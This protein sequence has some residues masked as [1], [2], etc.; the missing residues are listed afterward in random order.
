MEGDFI[1]RGSKLQAAPWLAPEWPRMALPM[2][3]FSFTRTFLSFHRRMRVQK[4]V[5][6]LCGPRRGL[7]GGPP[8]GTGCRGGG[9]PAQRGRGGR[10]PVIPGWGL[11]C[12]RPLLIK[13]PSQNSSLG[14][15]IGL[16]AL[17]PS[18][19]FAS[20]F[21]SALLAEPFLA[22]PP[23]SASCLLGF[24]AEEGPSWGAGPS[25]SL[26]LLLDS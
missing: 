14:L 9:G 5:R 6:G 11:F 19:L 10:G 22:S 16:R 18:P 17:S 3:A 24:R 1:I 4:C 12:L 23:Q 8:S 20:V 2:W 26:S 21:P 25:S 15:F 7:G 13:G